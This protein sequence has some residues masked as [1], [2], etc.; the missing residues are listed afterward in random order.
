MTAGKS[1][2]KINPESLL[3]KC[4]PASEMSGDE[5]YQ[6][7]L[8]LPN[9]HPYKAYLEDEMR[10]LY[11]RAM[12]KLTPGW[13]AVIPNR[14]LPAAT[15]ENP[16]YG[17]WDGEPTRWAPGEAWAFLNGEWTRVDSTDVGMNSRVQSKEEFT[18]RFGEL[19]PLPATAFPAS[20]SLSKKRYK[21]VDVRF[22]PD[23]CQILRR[24]ETTLSA[25]ERNRSR[26]RALCARWCIG[27]TGTR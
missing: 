14:S 10:K 4:K 17:S 5:M 16:S 7:A 1:N 22:A 2:N 11:G 24:S 15:R 20:S 9:D 23:S 21:T 13:K 25:N 26:G 18:A 27:L 19:P 12:E 8:N 3:E 6:V